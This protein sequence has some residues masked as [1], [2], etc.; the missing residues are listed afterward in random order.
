MN[1]T[2]KLIINALMVALVFVGT[3]SIRIPIPLTDGYI[4][5]GDSMIFLAAILFGWKTGAIAGG[6][7]SALADMIGYPHWIIP[8]L[9]IKGLMGAIIGLLAKNPPVKNIRLFQSASVVIFALLIQFANIYVSNL[10]NLE[11]IVKSSD[12]FSTVSDLQVSI[13]SFLTDMPKL[14]MA[15]LI[16]ILL[17]A[18]FMKLKFKSYFNFN[19]ILAMIISGSFM[20]LG[21][22]VAAS[23]MYGSFIVPLLSI[24]AN[25]LQFVIGMFI[26]I[27]I[28]VLLDK[29]KA[30]KLITK[31]D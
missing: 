25:I 8:T 30:L 2:K 22:Y 29:S 14:Y 5:G 21:Y 4:H 7:G 24:P 11:S 19:I 1:K 13:S 26:S 23:L 9:I 28:L 16:T 3:S 17:S 15:I 12:D 27:S 31:I 20:V 6:V 18:L 10:T